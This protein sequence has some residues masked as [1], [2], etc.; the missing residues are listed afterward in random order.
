MA[1]QIVVTTN[2]WKSDP[3]SRELIDFLQ[4][5]QTQLSLES[6]IVYYDFPSYADYEASTVRPDVLL[7]SPSVGFLAIK[8]VDRNL[9]QQSNGD[10]ETIDWLSMI[11]PETFT[12]DWSRVD[13]LGLGVHRRL[14]RYTQFSCPWRTVVK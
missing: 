13:F 2:R 4:K 9:F 10:V 7:F 3:S 8:T 6:S 5:Q 1:L 12:Q 14:Y 11:L